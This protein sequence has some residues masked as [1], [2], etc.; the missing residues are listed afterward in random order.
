MMFTKSVLIVLLLVVG[1]SLSV[2]L[3][4]PAV[5]PSAGKNTQTMRGGRSS[6]AH[7]SGDSESEVVSA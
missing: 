3:A 7:G 6:G 4:A 1:A 5:K 2:S